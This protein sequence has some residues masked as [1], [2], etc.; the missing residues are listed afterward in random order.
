MVGWMVAGAAAFGSVF[1]G[2]GGNKMVMDIAM[3]MPGGKWGA[4]VM[5][6]MFI[7]FLG[8][9]LETAGLIMLAAPIVT[10]VLVRLGFD[11]L[12]WGIVF[13]TLLQVAYISPPFGFALFY[14]KGV[15][16]PGGKARGNLLVECSLHWIADAV[17]AADHF[18][19]GSGSLAPMD[20]D[21]LTLDRFRNQRGCP[22]N[23]SG[24]CR[25]Q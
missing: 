19:S 12:W 8:M 4:L 16:P 21:E 6:I 10:P 1:A 17:R 18:V 3:A 23:R 24:C 15:T 25:F 20:V 22:S 2:I 9:F 5:S 7:F 11:P 14:L 13:M